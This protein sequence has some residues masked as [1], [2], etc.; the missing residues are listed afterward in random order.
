MGN[1]MRLCWGS[2]RNDPINKINSTI[3]LQSDLNKKSK[4]NL[5]LSQNSEF[6]NIHKN[7]INTTSAR[8]LSDECSSRL[9]LTEELISDYYTIKEPIGHGKYGTVH[10][11][12]SK[13]NPDFIV[14]IKVIKIRKIKSNFES[15]MKEI[16][17]LKEVSHPNIVKIFE[18]FKDDKKLYLVME[19]V[20]GKELFDYI[21]SKNQLLEHD[22]CII[23]E[24]LIKIVKYLNSLNICHRDLKPENIMV[25][26]KS[27]KIKL[28]DFGLSTHFNEF[29]S[30][31]SPVGTPYYVSP[32]VLKGDYNKECDM[33]SIGVITYILITG[34]PPFQ[35][36]S[37]TDIYKQI[38]AGDFYF[39][40]EDWRDISPE[41][42]DFVSK[43]IQ[44]NPKLRLTP[45]MALRHPWIKDSN[46][47]EVE[48]N[49]NM[50]ERLAHSKSPSDLKKEILLI[51][52]NLSD[53]QKLKQWNELFE[54]LEKNGLIQ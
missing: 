34:T 12:Y 19:Y 10:K 47:T 24:Q 18:I 3:E 31:V 4:R 53:E 14:A 49:N 41:A 21:V 26:T 22:A 9:K 7:K 50:L 33:W 52:I 8:K 48:I 54:S 51:L 35:A 36:E 6:K 29:K 1:S 23:I 42:K 20:K 46:S 16:Q 38:I 40:D 15:V 32:E 44:Q 37:M 25:D 39:Y 2:S 17:T 45:D 11:G 30:L 13:K 27:L 5:F 43:L 28:L